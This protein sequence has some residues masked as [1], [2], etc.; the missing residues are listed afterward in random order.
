MKT[1]RI[2]E[3]LHGVK[4]HHE[5][6]NSKGQFKEMHPEDHKG[7]PSQINPTEFKKAKS[8]YCKKEYSKKK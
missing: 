4:I 3:D 2:K 5:G 8:Q 6:Q 7:K 1:L